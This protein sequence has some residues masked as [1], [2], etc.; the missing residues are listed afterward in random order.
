MTSP[1]SSPRPPPRLLASRLPLLVSR[2]PPSHPPVSSPRRILA[3]KLADLGDVLNITP[4]L[5]ALRHTFPSA[6][7]DVLV[8][9]HTAAVLHDSPLVDEVVLF[10]K[11]EFEGWSALR[12]GAWLPIARRL[13]DLRGRDYDTV[14]DFHHLTTPLGRAKQRAL[15]AAAG[16]RTTVGLDNGFGGWFTHRVRDEGFGARREVEYW[17]ALAA[18]LGASTPDASL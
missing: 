7:L 13:R 9:P 6:Q 18:A 14:V 11:T 17:L 16:A 8:N 3:I 2:V 10:P 5:R 15:I 12:P 1:T 4:A